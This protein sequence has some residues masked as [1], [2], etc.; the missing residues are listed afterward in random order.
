MIKIRSLFLIAI[1]TT[2]FAYR[3]LS[4]TSYPGK[5][6][7]GLSEPSRQKSCGEEAAPF[8]QS[9]PDEF[10]PISRDQHDR[11]I[12]IPINYHVIYVAGDSIYMNVTVDN[13]N[14]PHCMWDIR[15]YDNNTFLLYPGFGFDYPGH[16][17]SL[18]GV[19][20]PGNYGLFL[21]DEFGT[22]GISATVTT[23]SGTVLASVNQGS[24]GNYTFLNFTAPE[25]NFTNGL[26]SMEVMEQQTA[27]LNSVYNEFG[28]SFTTSSVDSAVNAGWYY[29]TDSHKFET[30]QWENDDQYP[31]SY[32]HLTQ[33]T[34]REE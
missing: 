12:E 25:G 19:L 4:Q 9:A 30:G 8:I 29:A 17:Y 33:P 6:A 15:D 21:Y 34:N 11:N 5:S 26:L 13:Q 20:P 31:V 7:N 18:G 22:G 27:V 32:T 24:W 2:A 16:S 1:C 23:S 28:Y 14:Y 10:A 3:P